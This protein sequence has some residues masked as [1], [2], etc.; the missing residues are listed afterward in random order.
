MVRSGVD[1]S[2]SGDDMLLICNTGNVMA[3]SVCVCA[4]MRE[5]VCVCVYPYVALTRLIGLHLDD[6][7]HGN[8]IPT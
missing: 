5:C 1:M 6:Y 2:R 8:V 3:P 7:V 4:C